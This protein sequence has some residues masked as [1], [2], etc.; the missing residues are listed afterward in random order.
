MLTRT[1]ACGR[2]RKLI[3]LYAAGDLAGRRGRRVAAHVESCGACRRLVAEFDATREW[4][5]A[6]AEPPEFGAEFY[7]GLRAGVL[8]EIRRGDRRRPA[9]P[10]RAPLFAALSGRR[11]VYA[12]SFALALV[13]C[14][15]ALNFYS[16]RT[17]DAPR[18]LAGM[19][20]PART[21]PPIRDDVV[22][23][24]PQ[25]RAHR[26]HTTPER[27]SERPG[28]PPTMQRAA[29]SNPRKTLNT[30]YRATPEGAAGHELTAA[31]PTAAPPTHR[32]VAGA[33]VPTKPGEVARIEMQTAD[34]NIRIIWLAPQ[35][36]DAPAPKQR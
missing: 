30:P 33:A 23:P 16:R 34:P 1:T 28:R 18:P 22:T 32:A 6:A 8:D 4:A 14:A 9:A 25:P 15:L 26:P 13:A 36:R 24:A 35:E 12:T 7:E 29:G 2:A 10:R 21:P 27:A 17:M 5:R 20:S 3:P 31:S 19:S 11:L